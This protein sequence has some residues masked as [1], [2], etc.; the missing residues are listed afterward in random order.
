MNDRSLL[1]IYENVL[2]DK[3][4]DRADGLD[5]LHRIVHNPELSAGISDKAYHKLCDAL[6]H[7]VVREKTAYVKAV[8]AAQ[9]ATGPTRSAGSVSAVSER[10]T[11]AAAVV[12]ALVERANAQLRAKTVR[13]LT[14][15]IVQVLPFS[16]SGAG[17]TAALAA[18]PGTVAG[19]VFLEPLEINYTQTLRVLCGHAPHVEHFA[20]AEWDALVLFCVSAVDAQLALAGR[21]PD[22][23]ALHMTDIFATLNSL[24]T[25]AGA[26]L[27]PCA[28]RVFDVAAAWLQTHTSE[29][30][31]LEAVGVL[32]GVLQF[33]VTNNVGLYKRACAAAVA[34]VAALW[35]DARTPALKEQMVATLVLA[36]P[37]V[38][39][40][41]RRDRAA[42]APAMATLAYAL[43]AET[44]VE[45]NAL[46][47]D[48]LAL[49]MAHGRYVSMD[50]KRRDHAW[51]EFGGLEA[52]RP[53]TFY[54]WSVLVLV[55]SFDDYVDADL[56]EPATATPA[57]KPKRRRLL[58][59]AESETPSPPTS[60]LDHV[61]LRLAVDEPAPH[62]MRLAAFLTGT[63]RFL[64]G[65]AAMSP[66]AE[67][68]LLHVAL[69]DA[70]PSASWAIAA[71]VNVFRR[72]AAAGTLA[73]SADLWRRLWA[74]CASQGPLNVPTASSAACCL[75]L[76]TFLALRG[77]QAVPDSRADLHKLLGDLMAA[78]ATS[79]P[80][81]LN[82]FS[83][84][85][86]AALW[87][88]ANEPGVGFFLG[89][90][91]RSVATFGDSLLA[92]LRTRLDPPDDSRGP[93]DYSR[94]LEL[95]LICAGRQPGRMA[96]SAL[97]SGAGNACAMRERQSAGSWIRRA[98][99][100]QD[101]LAA[102]ADTVRYLLFADDSAAAAWADPRRPADDE[103]TL[104]PPPVQRVRVLGVVTSLRELCG[105]LLDQ[106]ADGSDHTVRAAA[107]AVLAALAFVARVGHDVPDC[108]P[109]FISP[110]APVHQFF[111]GVAAGPAHGQPVVPA[112]AAFVGPGSLV[113]LETAP[114]ARAVADIFKAVAVAQ[115][116]AQDALF[117][118]SQSD[119]FDDGDQRRGAEL[120]R[121]LADWHE[122]EPV[123]ALEAVTRLR[124]QIL[125]VEREGA[126]RDLAAAVDCVAGLGPTPMFLSCVLVLDLVDALVQAGD[127]DR[128]DTLVRALAQKLVAR[129][130]FE[131]AEVLHTV[132][133]GV[134]DRALPL[135]VPEGV[136][137][138]HPAARILQDLYNWIVRL[139]LSS[140]EVSSAVLVALADLLLHVQAADTN[141]GRTATAVP[142]AASLFRDL[143]RH[144]DVAVKYRMALLA[145][146]FFALFPATDHHAIY[147][148]VHKQLE[149][150]EENVE[151]MAL[152][153]FTFAQLA[154]SEA[155][156]VR[157]AVYNLVEVGQLESVRAYAACCFS[158]IAAARGVR[159]AELFGRYASQIVYTWVQY[160]IPLAELPIAVFGLGS[161]AELYEG[162]A[163][164]LLAQAYLKPPGGTDVAAELLADMAAVLGRP[165]AD[166]VEHA[167]HQIAAYAYL[168]PGARPG[169]DE[170]VTAA[171]GADRV[172]TLWRERVLTVVAF[173]VA[174]VDL[175]GVSDADV[176]AAGHAPEAVL[177]RELNHY[178]TLDYDDQ[179]DTP[180]EPYCTAEDA[181]TAIDDARGRAGLAELFRNSALLA[182]TAR[183]VLDG[184]RVCS[185]GQQRCVVVKQTK[186]VVC[187]AQARAH[188]PHFAR[189][190]LH[191]L[192]P[193]AEDS[194]CTADVLDVVRYLAVHGVFE[195]D[196]RLFVRVAMQ[197]AAHLCRLRTRPP[198]VSRFLA[199]FRELQTALA[200]HDDVRDALPVLH[201]AAD[202]AAGG[203]RDWRAWID[204]DSRPLRHL[205]AGIGPFDRLAADYGRAL[206]GADL[207]A[208]VEMRRTLLATDADAVELFPALVE[209]A[210]EP[211]LSPG[212]VEWATGV[213]GRAYAATGDFPTTWYDG[214]DVATD[215]PDGLAPTGTAL[216][217]ARAI[218]YH[219]S[220]LRDSADPAVQAA[221]ESSLRPMVLYLL[222]K[223]YT[224]ANFDRAVADDVRAARFQGF[225][226]T[227]T[228]SPAVADPPLADYA[229]W[230]AAATAG[231]CAALGVA[232]P[233][234]RPLVA[235]LA[236]VHAPAEKL[237]R[238]V[239]LESLATDDGRARV[240]ALFERVLTA[241]PAYARHQQLVIGTFLYLQCADVLVQPWRER[242]ACVP[243][244]RLPTLVH[245]AVGCNMFSAAMLLCESLWKLDGRGALDA[246]AADIVEI[247]TSI[248]D[249]D[250]FY[251]STAAY[252]LDSLARTAEYEN[253]TAALFTYRSGMADTAG[254]AGQTRAATD[255]LAAVA[256]A[257]HTALA[258][259]VYNDAAVRLGDRS[260]FDPEYLFQ[261]AWQLGQW[262]L[263]PPAGGGRQQLTYELLQTAAADGGLA[264]ALAR[265]GAGAFAALAEPA[266]TARS[267]RERLL[268]LASIAEMAD[269]AAVV[270][271]R[272][273][274]AVLDRFE[275]RLAWTDFRPLHAFED[276]LK[277]RA[278]MLGLTGRRVPELRPRLALAEARMVRHLG[279]S[280]RDRRELQKAAAACQRLHTLAPAVP[281][282][283]RAAFEAVL[284]TE[285]AEF[286]WASGKTGAAIAVLERATHAAGPAPALDGAAGGHAESLA[287]ALVGL[288]TPYSSRAATLGRWTAQER[289]ERPEEIMRKF[290]AAAIE[291]IDDAATGADKAHAYRE[292]AR[293]CDAQ[294]HGPVYAEDFGRLERLRGQKRK[295]VADLESLAAATPA[296]SERKRIQVHL[297]RVRIQ[298]DAVDSEHRQLVASRDDFVHKSL[299]FYLLS[300]AESD[301]H[302]EDVYRFCSLWLANAFSAGAN[303]AAEAHVGHTPSARLVVCINQFSSRLLELDTPFQ[304]LLKA[305]VGRI[306]RD[307]P[308]HGLYQLAGVRTALPK[309]N[310]R[311]VTARLRATAASAVWRQLQADRAFARAYIGPIERAADNFTRL[312]QHSFRRGGRLAF[313]DVSNAAWWRGS[314]FDVPPPTVHVAVRAD[315]DY[316]SVPRIVAFRPALVLASG[317][318]QPK[319]CTCTADDGRDHKLLVKGGNDD[320]R[321]DAIM[322]QVFGQVNE[323]FAKNSGTRQRGLHIRTYKVVPLGHTAGVIEF[324]EHTV[325]LMDVLS[326]LHGRLNPGDYAL[327]VCR[328]KMKDAQARTPADRVAVYADV[329]AHL[330]PVLSFF[331]LERF[332]TPRV[333]LR[334]RT[335]YTRATA[336]VSVVGNVLGL[337]DRHC[338]NILLDTATGEPVHIDLGVAF[339]QGKVLPIPERVP[340]RLTRDIVDGMGLSG[341]DGVFRRCCEL[342]LDLLRAEADSIMTIL[343]VLKYDPLYSWTI[344]PLRKKRLQDDGDVDVEPKKTRLAK[345]SQ[346]SD[347]DT[348]VDPV[349]TP[350][351]ADGSDD[352]VSL[353]QQLLEKSLSITG[354]SG[355]EHALVTVRRKL[356][357]TW[358]SF[359]VVNELI[360]D[361]TAVE[362]LALLYCGWAPFY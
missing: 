263:H 37:G 45:R 256:R 351:L 244:L 293:F 124:L 24:L 248:D 188:R 111:A 157:S 355:A 53:H 75:F 197:L 3:V 303:A 214:L 347:P 275:A 273:L 143:F 205:L 348:A 344:S 106:A 254:D 281:D 179:L 23:P 357:T 341:T 165:S 350:R 300:L 339:D 121:R 129:Y 30:C 200:A 283:L 148:D 337:G 180:L 160:D 115:T 332:R 237:F 128:L 41:T 126:G 294:L 360:R 40:Y 153:A 192:L 2:S 134:L 78:P 247:Y 213:C 114:Y 32:N 140:A 43:V 259:A 166:L 63:R 109:G 229:G 73:A 306:C 97:V 173:V 48:D 325:A 287:A 99:L 223:G 107:F 268:T 150:L 333:W 81:R 265:A 358:S 217:S 279:A 222:R 130:D 93:S 64:S 112:L 85:L 253:D 250:A 282:T 77:H 218:V 10:L 255:L 17:G 246:V 55:A 227:Q 296:G 276:L 225:D 219:V 14:Q 280:A 288:A 137:P 102:M 241:G 305:V 349:P 235:L 94:V 15:H 135:W 79:A 203:D 71:L 239:V 309:E 299:R 144:A 215:G 242:L 59:T 167:F 249:P 44:R 302:V 310:A 362:N 56:F 209:L 330:A 184:L 72:H 29:T 105:R 101:H 60:A 313:D 352:L 269:V 224:T 88:A 145:P 138:A 54:A 201:V 257:G 208:N 231:L 36:R 278:T 133:V 234:F 228:A 57:R 183:L 264:A 359:Q 49:P 204:A 170:R 270:D 68:R 16:F 261:T 125:A 338:N 69:T 187:L 116:A 177:W 286:L 155:A 361:A 190:I 52:V 26:R 80:G 271:G 5:S 356:A 151:G 58:R 38:D 189:T 320:L 89:R 70:P 163:D 91:D 318:S 353:E 118:R 245:A 324:V 42:I 266:P 196:P 156:V 315:R 314:D 176:A 66:A 260:E 104:S 132:V 159:P 221:T 198:A 240:G 82:D 243:G 343:D 20:A 220:A 212:F 108:V 232:V 62:H 298:F 136:S 295:E 84:E 161:R 147:L 290:L 321:Q 4:K 76:S 61:V 191:A 131:R 33:S 34:A 301:K 27:A 122:H 35:P 141:Y 172:R 326:D 354:E 262:D 336:A 9:L 1:Q 164:E 169:I 12:R 87:A 186:L 50:G 74:F 210:R 319:I 216:R 334:N 185:N 39:Y 199:W 195:H 51:L 86:W 331:F 83:C 139:R 46:A 206:L 181:L 304:R 233:F 11:H 322:E 22:E 25:A 146:R 252:S 284:M 211:G 120:P 13:A 154:M 329:A 67:E 18:G 182:Y 307:H 92:W 297:G 90:R 113:D 175:R 194:A 346:P 178:G 226:L 98:V 28:D 311:D 174:R 289:R 171:I 285:T 272:S 65:D 207:D 19:T 238:Y 340:F 21:S 100:A 291:S 7:V 317:L 149:T 8:A 335:A 110:G 342:S 103:P 47:L 292:F 345:R 308:Y 119:D 123:L 193:L 277:L 328:R 323:L 327:N 117:D 236:V 6:F 96:R 251:S 230:V 258:R 162:Y 274:D 202:I 267:V 142:A 127:R 316:S 312:A 152:R 31:A 158:M 95:L 168:V